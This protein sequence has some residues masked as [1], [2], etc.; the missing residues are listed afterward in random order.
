MA[1]ASRALRAIRMNQIA[2]FIK[3]HPFCTD[4]DIATHLDCTTS[5]ARRYRLAVLDEFSRIRTYAIAPMIARQVDDLA[6]LEQKVV[7]I[8]DDTGVEVK[9]RLGAANMQLRV[10]DRRAKLL[11]LDAKRKLD[12]SVNQTHQPPA[13]PLAQAFDMDAF[14]KLVAETPLLA[15]AIEGEIV[16]ED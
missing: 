1:H 12:I 16:N 4:E 3:E 11:G 8:L 7:D 15:T 14:N 5:L 6:A 9:D 2:S 10:M 13:Q